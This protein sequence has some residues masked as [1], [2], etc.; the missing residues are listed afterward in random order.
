VLSID[1]GKLDTSGI[2]RF[3]K[4]DYS[5]E[6]PMGNIERYNIKNV[7]RQFLELTEKRSGY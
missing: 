5:C 3:L 2:E 4:G 7:T 1:T 6:V